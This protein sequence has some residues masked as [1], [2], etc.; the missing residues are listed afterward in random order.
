MDGTDFLSDRAFGVEIE[1]VGFDPYRANSILM[2]SS[3]PVLLRC[4]MTAPQT[5]PDN[6]FEFW[7]IMHDDTVKAGSHL[8]PDA[9]FELASPISQGA[10]GWQDIAEVMQ[11]MFDH[12]ALVNDTSNLQVQMDLRDVWENPA[13][14]LAVKKA[15][16]EIYIVFE[17][18]ID[19][20]IRPRPYRHRYSRPLR[21]Y[22]EPGKD[23]RFAL[24]LVCDEINRCNEDDLEKLFTWPNAKPAVKFRGYKTAEYR[25]HQGVLNPDRALGWLA[26]CQGITEAGM[27]IAQGL[28]SLDLMMESAQNPTTPDESLMCLLQFIGKPGLWPL[29]HA[30][31]MMP[32]SAPVS[33]KPLKNTTRPGARLGP[34]LFDPSRPERG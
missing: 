22:F 1:A 20:I 25:A 27:Q 29:L 17:P 4:G 31:E 14:R 7:Q 12:G 6:R 23:G 30:P 26:L 11:A 8:P 19:S 9:V 15:I 10:N 34:Q 33:M 28:S 21:D 24:Q 32:R 18:G 3:R 13:L 16:T 5:P 2:D